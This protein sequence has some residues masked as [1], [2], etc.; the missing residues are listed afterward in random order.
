MSLIA[1]T[2]APSLKVVVTVSEPPSTDNVAVTDWMRQAKD[3]IDTLAQGNRELQ[4]FLDDTLVVLK[5]VRLVGNDLAVYAGTDS[6]EGVVTEHV[7]SLYLRTN[8]GASTTLY[9]KESGDGTN[10]GWI[11]K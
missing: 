10:T 3:A 9:V 6:P 11:A 7:G 5:T 2:K 4:R 1:W 8:G